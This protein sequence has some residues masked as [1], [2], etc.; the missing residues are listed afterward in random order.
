MLE[1]AI[2]V[3]A[4][5]LLERFRVAAPPLPMTVRSFVEAKLLALIRA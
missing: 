2:P 4:E 3:D 5:A 1:G